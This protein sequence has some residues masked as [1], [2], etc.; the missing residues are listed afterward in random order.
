[1]LLAAVRGGD[2][3]PKTGEGRS[4]SEKRQETARRM[5]RLGATIRPI[6][7]PK[8]TTTPSPYNT[9][10][11]HDR[12]NL[13]TQGG[14]SIGGHSSGARALP[15]PHK[16]A[17][18]NNKNHHSQR[19]KKALH[20][21]QALTAE[22][23]LDSRRRTAG[24]TQAT[25]ACGEPPPPLGEPNRHTKPPNRQTGGANGCGTRVV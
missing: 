11:T 2:K 14:R 7:V 23:G 15:P 1:M 19:R 21:H 3:E 18:R 22:F 9:K 12:D 24:P 8:T 10:R 5:A 20:S 25:G 6:G 16:A 4:P 13:P 17:S